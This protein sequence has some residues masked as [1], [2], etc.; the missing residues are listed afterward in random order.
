LVSTSEIEQVRQLNNEGSLE[1][2]SRYGVAPIVVSEVEI[3]EGVVREIKSNVGADLVRVGIVL[4]ESIEK[5]TRSERES[6]SRAYK[7]GGE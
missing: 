1:Q 3:A 7:V 6:K 4:N 5:R 2:L